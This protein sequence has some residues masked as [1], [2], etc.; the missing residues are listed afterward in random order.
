MNRITDQKDLER[1]EATG[2]PT[3]AANSY[4]ALAASAQAHAQRIA[5]HFIPDGA[6]PTESLT[7]TYAELIGWVHAAANLFHAHGVGVADAVSYA[8]P[9]VPEVYLTVFG[10]EACGIVNP[11]NPLLEDEHMAGIMR[12]AGAKVLVTVGPDVDATTWAKMQRVIAQVP[13]LRTVFTVSAHGRNGR[14]STVPSSTVGGVQVL[15]LWTALATRPRD[16]LLA[17]VRATADDVASCFHTGGTTGS[18]KLAQRTHR[19]Q[20]ANAW[21]LQ[22]GLGLA[23]HRVLLCGLPLF[24]ANGVLV[25]AFLPLMN[26]HTVV[27][28][29]AAGYRDKAII[30]HFW[31]IIAHYRVNLFSAVPTILKALLT[32]PMNGADLGSLEYVVCGAA[33]L[34]TQLFTDFEQATGIKI[35]EGYGFT[36]GV[37]VNTLN[38]AHGERKIGSIGMR[39][40]LHRMKVV[41]LDAQ[42][43]YM[44]DAAAN[45]SGVFVAHGINIFK[46][47]KDPNDDRKAWVEINGERWYNTGDIGYVDADGYFWITGRRKE[48]I[49]RAGHNIDPKSIEEPMGRHPAVAAVAAVSRPDAHAGELPV[50]YVELKPGATATEEDLLAHAQAHINERAAVPKHVRIIPQLPVTAVGKVFKPELEERQIAEVYTD[51]ACGVPGV[52]SASVELV[53]QPDGRNLVV[54]TV[55]GTDGDP[56]V[57][58][59]LTKALSPFTIAYRIEQS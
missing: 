57:H 6:V 5:L 31:E 55:T 29:G 15:D 20:L 13:T 17:P 56:S 14:P 42:D 36:E 53:K 41:V 7:W 58:E 11:I 38:P 22:M 9:N 4:T 23:P 46:G 1:I 12:A 37:C 28:A 25:T 34:S 33:P 50:A 48:L 49:I 51:V 44:R 19:N 35:I 54:I 30:S 39:L 52:Q 2:A 43:R 10:A 3:L 16:G 18:P 27:V 59:A 40:P 21:A 45:E 32:I 24:H 47:Y 26:G 8:L